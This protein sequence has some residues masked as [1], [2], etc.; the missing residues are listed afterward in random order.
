MVAMCAIVYQLSIGSYSK[1]HEKLLC[2]HNFAPQFPVKNKNQ[3]SERGPCRGFGLVHS[4]G[5][6]S[7]PSSHSTQHLVNLHHAMSI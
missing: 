5:L 6:P 2:I 4:V 1:V 3:T 7:S